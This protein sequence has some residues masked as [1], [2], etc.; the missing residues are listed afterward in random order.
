MSLLNRAREKF[1][2]RED[3]TAKADKRAS[4]SSVSAVSG[5]TEFRTVDLRAGFEAALQRGCLVTC[6][7]CGAFRSR[8][9]SQPDGWCQRYRVG[10]WARVPF[11]CDGYKPH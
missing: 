4:V 7:R 1:I 11:R 6:D 9:G 3:G 8:P 10:T 5:K 2:F